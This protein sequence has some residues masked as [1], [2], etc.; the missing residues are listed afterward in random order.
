MA[1]KP[2]V[3]GADGSPESMRAVE[4]AAR[5][6]GLR[7]TSLRIV[8]IASMPP[9]MS[10]NPATQDT[11][12]NRIEEATND[13]LTTAASQAAAAAPGWPSKPTLSTTPRPPTP[14]WRSARTP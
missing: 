10:P 1:T 3:A 11:V 2:V 14:W 7:G 13:A 4:W 12:A 5:E 8:A 6:A 9:R